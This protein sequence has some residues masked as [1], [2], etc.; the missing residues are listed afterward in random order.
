MHDPVK[1][2]QYGK[3]HDLLESEGYE[4][5]KPFLP[6]EWKLEKKFKV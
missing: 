1:V 3:D 6:S 4:W 2:I 5:I